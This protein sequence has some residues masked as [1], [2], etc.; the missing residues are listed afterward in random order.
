[1]SAANIDRQRVRLADH[2]PAGG[3]CPVCAQSGADLRWV[4][5]GTPY[6]VQT[7]DVEGPAHGGIQTIHDV[8][9][10]GEVH[11]VW[12]AVEGTLKKLG[13][14]NVL[15]IC[16]GCAAGAGEAVGY[17]DV[18]DAEEAREQAEQARDQARAE[19]AKLERRVQELE[20]AVYA[21]HTGR[22]AAEASLAA[23]TRHSD[24]PASKP[25]AK[26]K[27]KS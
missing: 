2:P 3:Q 20:D 17:G 13:I 24:E 10:F 6:V 7:A 4:T 9:G 27:G 21:E 12:D 8:P 16:E 26:P 11:T 25:P 15:T 23:A 1:M 18:L 14:G 19:V 22:V 5:F